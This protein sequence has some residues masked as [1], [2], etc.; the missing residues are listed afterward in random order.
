MRNTHRTSRMSYYQ[1]SDATYQAHKKML[2][3]SMSKMQMFEKICPRLSNIADNHLTMLI[4]DVW[5]TMVKQL[6]TAPPHDRRT[7]PDTPARK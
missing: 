1:T 7:C 4:P 6:D 5:D 3:D 2:Y